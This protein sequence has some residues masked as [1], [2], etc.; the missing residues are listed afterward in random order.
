M[1]EFLKLNKMKYLPKVA[2]Y[3]YLIFYNSMQKVSGN[4]KKNTN[5]L[6][7]FKLT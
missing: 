7:I 6:K 5:I 3:Q 1:F 2:Y 4:F